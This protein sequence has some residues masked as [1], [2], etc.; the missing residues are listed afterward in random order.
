MFVVH[1]YLDTSVLIIPS[2]LSRYPSV[3]EHDFLFLNCHTY[4]NDEYNIVKIHLKKRKDKHIRRQIMCKTIFFYFL[5]L[6][7]LFCLFFS[8]SS[9]RITLNHFCI[10]V[11]VSVQLN[12]RQTI[13]SVKNIVIIVWFKKC[14]FR[15]TNKT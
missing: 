2:S 10:L 15:D 14:S 8:S 1:Q 3:S 5:A 11:G 4:D 13:M 6:L 9:H 7:F 12:R